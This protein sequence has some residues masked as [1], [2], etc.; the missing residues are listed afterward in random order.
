MKM[1]EREGFTYDSYIDIFDGGPTMCVPTD[2]VRTIRES[3][4]LTLAG[5]A[6]G[7]GGE[8]YILATGRLADYRACYGHLRLEAGDTAVVE[9]GDAALLG[10]EAGDTFD[11]MGR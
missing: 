7:I 8:S 9:T 2:S 4:T 1:L 5:T 6:D 10:I 3:R 11:A